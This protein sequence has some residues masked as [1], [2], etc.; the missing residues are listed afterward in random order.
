[1]LQ[2]NIKKQMIY[3]GTKLPPQISNINDATLFEKERYILYHS[4]SEKEN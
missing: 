4:F 3:S 1:M 2:P